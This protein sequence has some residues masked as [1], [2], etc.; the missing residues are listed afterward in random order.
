MDLVV[1]QWEKNMFFACHTIAHGTDMRRSPLGITIT[2][3]RAQFHVN[4]NESTL[5][6]RKILMTMVLVTF[7][8]K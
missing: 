7:K 1:P 8:P 2:R 4:F 3:S 5:T 6:S